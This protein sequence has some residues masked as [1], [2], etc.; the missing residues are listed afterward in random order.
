MSN[1]I[2]KHLRAM[3]NCEVA[4]YCNEHKLDFVNNHK[5]IKSFDNYVSKSI[6]QLSKNKATKELIEQI[7]IGY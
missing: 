4:E 3:R 7:F 1:I 2:A 5:L 6:K